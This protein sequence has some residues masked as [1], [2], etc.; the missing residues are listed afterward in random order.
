MGIFRNK[1][2]H[3]AKPFSVEDFL[4][5]RPQVEAK[6]NQVKEEVSEYV[7]QYDTARKYYEDWLRR[8]DLAKTKLEDTPTETLQMLYEQ[9]EI[10]LQMAQDALKPLIDYKDVA[11]AKMKAVLDGM[12]AFDRIELIMAT[13]AKASNHN[14]NVEDVISSF[15]QSTFDAGIDMR[16]IKQTEYIMA[17]HTELKLGRNPETTTLQITQ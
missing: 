14:A 16:D 6:F 2:L 5:S 17:A 7:E 4:A 8:R 15:A 10:N 3:E 9:A 11:E 13:N 1:K 12:K